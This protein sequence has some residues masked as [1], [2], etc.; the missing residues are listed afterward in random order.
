MS[1][2]SRLTSPS[3]LLDE[4]HEHPGTPE[5]GGKEMPGAVR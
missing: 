1:M 2:A 3:Q 5:M 4:L